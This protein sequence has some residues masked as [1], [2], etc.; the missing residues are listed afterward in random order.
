MTFKLLLNSLVPLI[1]ISFL[2]DTVSICW[3]ISVEGKLDSDSLFNYSVF[4]FF[5]KN[6]SEFLLIVTQV[7]KNCT[8]IIFEMSV[9]SPHYTIL[10]PYFHHVYYLSSFSKAFDLLLASLY[11]L[12]RLRERAQKSE[13]ERQRDRENCLILR[14]LWTTCFLFLLMLSV[15]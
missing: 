4:H 10:L 13:S 7:V 1:F 5:L 6:I 2:S 8:G 11:H 12:T 15:C 3:S 9:K 14:Q